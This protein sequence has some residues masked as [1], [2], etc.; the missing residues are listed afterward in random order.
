MKKVKK[1]NHSNIKNIVKE[2]FLNEKYLLPESRIDSI[3]NEYLSERDEYLDDENSLEDKTNFSSKTSNAL[4]DMVEGINEMLG[5]LEVIKEKEGNVLVYQ[6]EYS[7]E[8]L[9]DVIEDLVDIVD[10]I[11][12][13][14]ELSSD[15]DLDY[16]DLN[17]E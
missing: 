17:D 10:R 4:G 9:E 1:I 15:K 5:D 16:D 12:V 11:S 2:H 13:L 8:Y 7:D 14:T 3:I 6:N